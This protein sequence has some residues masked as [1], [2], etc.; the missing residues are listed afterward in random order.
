[1]PPKPEEVRKTV[2]VLQHVRDYHLTRGDRGEAPLKLSTP[3]YRKGADRLKR[4]AS[5]EYVALAI[6]SA[7]ESSSA[8]ELPR[9]IRNY[10]QGVQHAFKVLEHVGKLDPSLLPR[11]RKAAE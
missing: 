9:F 7:S 10:D 2:G 3:A 11:V 5:L 6:H 4:A 8:R 1:M